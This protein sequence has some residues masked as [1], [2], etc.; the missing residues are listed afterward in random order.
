MIDL[1]C[2]LFSKA[3]FLAH[4]ILAFFIIIF[5]DESFGAWESST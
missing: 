3:S 5:L 4:E 2:C 1:N